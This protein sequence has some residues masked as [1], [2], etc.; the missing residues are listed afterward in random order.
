M[1][2]LKKYIY[3]LIPAVGLA[4][5]SCS[6]EELVVPDSGEVITGETV[7]ISGSV[8]VPGM[9][10]SQTRG[11]LGDTPKPNLQLTLLEFSKGT[12]ATNSFLTNIYQ[13]E[14]T[15]TTA[16]QNG[17]IVHF[18]VE[19]KLTT[20]P[21]ILH[22]MIA[23]DYVSCNYG[24]EAEILP[25]ISVGFTSDGLSHEAY[26]GCVVFENGYAQMTGDG[27]NQTATLLPEVK[28]SLTE[29]PVI[30]NFCKISI[31]NK[32]NDS[33]ELYGFQLVNVP[34]SGTIAPYSVAN[35]NIPSLL[36]G[37]T[38]VDYATASSRYAGILPANVS[39][40][41]LESEIR[42]IDVNS[43]KWTQVGTPVYMY[44]HPFESARRTYMIVHGRYKTADGNTIKD[45]CFYKIDLGST[46][47]ATDGMFAYLDLLR[48]YN[49]NVVINSVKAP[50]YSTPSEAI[51]GTTFNNLSASV[52]T[53]AMLNVSDGTNMLIVNETSHVFV[54][55]QPATF[56]YRYIKNVGAGQTVDNS[57]PQIK[58]LEAGAV[59]KSFTEPV[60]FTDAQG[61]SWMAVTIT[62]NAPS[63]T[64]RTQSFTV[65]D[66]NG[67]GRTISL[68]LHNP[69]N[70]STA[71]VYPGTNNT[72]PATG[73]GMGT[74][75]SAAGDAL[76]VYFDLPDGLPEEM[77][78]LRFQLEANPQNIENNPIGTLVVYT[79]PSLFESNNGV[80]AIS[81]VKT[82]SWAEYNYLYKAGGGNEVDINSPNPNHTVR[83]RF[84]TI[85]AG[86][87]KTEV[88]IHNPYFVNTT[89]TFTRQ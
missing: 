23:D 86:T 14:T 4:F 71:D 50:G 26:W 78:P 88:I 70:Y 6:Q 53:K 83:C 49:Y 21:R 1:K 20:E 35:Q 40:R 39:F 47:N 69:W 73:T 3:A 12:D 10:I 31:E 33:F 51:D 85:T 11:Q 16:V 34:S 15:T 57:V 61:V 13:A 79:G 38:M 74:A 19:L 5:G 72:R 17:G 27:D 87:G 43:N 64:N 89:A 68:V 22:L 55:D 42:A 56:M 36:N 75:G 45:Y 62:P 77:F 28:T 44:E 37:N 8:A 58:G 41:N 48:N 60:E 52:E 9:E 7:T 67:L 82:V 81:Y 80:P 30:R 18:T 46:K 66:G 59:V 32:A 24:S 84:R 54:T 2:G 65:V 29:V 76:T 25:S 63:A